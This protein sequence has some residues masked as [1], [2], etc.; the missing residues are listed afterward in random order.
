MTI[1]DARRADNWTL[2]LPPRHPAF[3]WPAQP[4]FAARSRRAAS[5]MARPVKLCHVGY[6]I[7]RQLER[8][9]RDCGACRMLRSGFGSRPQWRMAGEASDHDARICASSL[10]RE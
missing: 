10:P 4:T 8:G 1:L 5:L 2:V 3:R 9:S 6:V 7:S